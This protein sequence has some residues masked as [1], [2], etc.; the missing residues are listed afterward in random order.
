MMSTPI[1]L[2]IVDRYGNLLDEPGNPFFFWSMLFVHV[3]QIHESA[4]VVVVVVNITKER[5]REPK[6]KRQCAHTSCRL[7]CLYDGIAS[8]IMNFCKVQPR[9]NE[10]Q[11]SLLSHKMC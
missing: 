1:W 9:S 11:R 6:I 7:S 4:H 2:F 5:L 10:L 8:T 3:I